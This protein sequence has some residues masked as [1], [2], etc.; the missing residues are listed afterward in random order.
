MSNHS[1]EQRAQFIA[2]HVERQ[3]AGL[4]ASVDQDLVRA[5]AGLQRIIE[6]RKLGR[7]TGSC[8]IENVI[9]TLRRAERRQDSFVATRETMAAL[10]S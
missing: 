2:D 4:A 5:L 9:N 10:R 6:D 8:E 3:M 1:N 7:A